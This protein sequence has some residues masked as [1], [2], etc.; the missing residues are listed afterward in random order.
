VVNN[1]AVTASSVLDD[2]AAVQRLLP[3]LPEGQRTPQHLRQTLASPQF[4]SA[5]A[6]LSSSLHSD[7]YNSVLANLGLS[8]GA[9]AQALMR[10]ENTEAFLLAV[11][12]AYAA[13]EGSSD[14]NSSEGKES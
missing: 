5:L 1:D 10:G 3:H 12:E 4:R 14:A 7:N 9:G 6:H 2:E 8:P 13:S 11:I